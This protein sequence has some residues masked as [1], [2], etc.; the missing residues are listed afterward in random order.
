[1]D[2]VTNELY[3][4]VKTLEKRQAAIEVDI[5]TNVKVMQSKLYKKIDPVK[6][7]V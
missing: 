2:F 6:N 1:M 4:D 3:A 5:N 7:K